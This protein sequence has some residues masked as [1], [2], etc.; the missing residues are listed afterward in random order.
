MKDIN[1]QTRQAITELLLKMADDALIIGHRNSEW[2]GLGPMLEEDIAFSS[3]AQDKLGHALGLYTLLHEHFNMPDVDT[4]ALKRKAEDRKCCQL[5]EL[6]IGGYDFSLV[7]QFLFDH[8]EM[9]RYQYLQQSS[10]EPLAQF[11]AKV[12][13]EIKY[14]I[15]HSRYL[16]WQAMCRL[17]RSAIAFASGFERG[18]SLC[19]GHF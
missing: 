2:T 8:A 18:I 7:R 5:V 19:L 13:G 16:D 17:R 9:L 12:R 14:H 1:A 4:L 15:L 3:M 11:A 10:F 6:P